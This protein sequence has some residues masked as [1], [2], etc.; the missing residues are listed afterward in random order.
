MAKPYA[1]DARARIERM[2]SAGLISREQAARLESALDLHSA[3]ALQAAEGGTRHR[4]PLFVV[5]LLLG[6]ILVFFIFMAGGSPQQVQDVAASLN[7]PETVGA[8]NKTL[9]FSI[10]IFILV[11]VPIVII[12]ASYNSLVTREEAVLTSW[13]QVES[14]FQRRA[15]LVP[16]LVETVTTYMRHERNTLTEVTGQRQ[17]DFSRLAGAVDRLAEGQQEFAEA[18]A[19]ENDMIEDQ[20]ALDRLLAESSAL[21]GSIRN[22]FAVV[23]DYP[24]LASSDQFLELQA[25]LEGTENRIN[26]ARMRFNEAVGAFNGASRRIPGNLAAALGGF[27]R[28]AYFKAE[29]G[30]DEPEDTLFE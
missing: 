17:A 24:E 13:G 25:Q 7:Q 9:S 3:S 6:L 11:V 22:L 30:A 29:E 1:G 8:M 16:A 10:A 2:E 15:D 27:K 21:G 26:V 20:Q 18:G 28:K 4:V 19:A 14:Q 23:E 12:A 5:A